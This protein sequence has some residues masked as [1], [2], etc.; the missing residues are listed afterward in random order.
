MENNTR[1]Q[2]RY[3]LALIFVVAGLLFNWFNIG[4]PNFQMFGSV[5]NWLVFIGLI[6]NI[7]TT[8]QFF[9]IKKQRKT[10]ERMEFIATKALKITFSF[11]MI[12]AFIVIILDGIKT[13]TI[14][15]HLFMSYMVC[16]LLAVYLISYNILLRN[17]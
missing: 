17:N 2:L 15:Y 1:I 8:L 12:G 6:F 9:V 16:V 5:G 11:T 10:D 14:P 4:S 13:I 7:I 3:G